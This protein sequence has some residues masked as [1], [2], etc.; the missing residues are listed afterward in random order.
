MQNQAS[1]WL[2]L[3]VLVV[4][5]VVGYRI[6]LDKGGPGAVGGAS[7]LI[8]RPSPEIEGRDVDGKPFKLSD[9]RGKVVALDFWGFW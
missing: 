4:A 3:L 6:F 2:F 1:K 9:Y 8:G 7:P 5:G